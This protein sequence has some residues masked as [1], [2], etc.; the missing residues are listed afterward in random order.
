MTDTALTTIAENRNID[1]AIAAW[2]DAK[3]RQSHKTHVPYSST[4]TQFRAALR[5][6][7]LDLDTLARDDGHGRNQR[8]DITLIAQAF[9]SVSARGKTIAPAT[10]YPRLPIL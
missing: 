3:G 5:A 6:K 9:V 4:I 10:F 2:L 8:R 7:G 1:L